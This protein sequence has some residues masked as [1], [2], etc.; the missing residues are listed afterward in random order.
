MKLYMMLC[1][2]PSIPAAKLDVLLKSISCWFC[3]LI[4]GLSNGPSGNTPQ[5]ANATAVPLKSE[6]PLAVASPVDSAKNLNAPRVKDIQQ[7]QIVESSENAAS[8]LSASGSH[9]SS[10]DPVLLPSQ[11]SP[12][13]SAVGSIH[14][15][16]GSQ[17]GPGE[18]VE[19][20][21]AGNKSASPEICMTIVFVPLFLYIFTHFQNIKTFFRFHRE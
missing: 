2:I 12:P 8:I 6:K 7:Y 9:L 13:P 4:T 1:K 14:R 20:K 10:S 18:M 5:S 15:E 3:S 16:V 21:P 11:D 19:N 17:R